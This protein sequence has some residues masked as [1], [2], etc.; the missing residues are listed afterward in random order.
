MD[1]IFGE[2]GGD[3]MQYQDFNGAGVVADSDTI[4]NDDGGN[5]LLLADECKNPLRMNV[6]A[7]E[8]EDDADDELLL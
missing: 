3:E 1:E 8:E 7:L 6:A 4:P 2:N 5:P